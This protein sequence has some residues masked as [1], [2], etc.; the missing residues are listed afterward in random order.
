MFFMFWLG[1]FTVLCI[2]VFLVLRELRKLNA[3]LKQYTTPVY[4]VGGHAFTLEELKDAIIKPG[5]L[6]IREKDPIPRIGK[7]HGGNLGDEIP[8]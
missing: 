7:G 4:V 6:E 2:L 3:R 8:F 5:K 1:P